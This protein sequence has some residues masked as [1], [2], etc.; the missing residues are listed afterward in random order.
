MKKINFIILSFFPFLIFFSVYFFLSE[1]FFR[2]KKIIVENFIGR[3]LNDL[4]FWS[5]KNGILIKILKINRDYSKENGYIV[6]QI[7]KPE[8]L[9]S[10]Q[11]P[12]SVEI[13]FNKKIKGLELINLSFE[14]AK[15]IILENGFS[16]EKRFI[17]CLKKPNDIIICNSDENENNI[18]TYVSRAIK[19]DIIIGMLSGCFCGEVKKHFESIGFTVICLNKNSEKIDFEHDFVIFDQ[20][21]K[22]GSIILKDNILYLFHF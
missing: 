13:V 5:S 1:Y 20:R 22:K 10:S 7:P 9:I 14:N 2:Y 4:I 3:N 8:C 15:D 17:P 16:F 19:K 11:N 6:S 21:P 18:F 12:L